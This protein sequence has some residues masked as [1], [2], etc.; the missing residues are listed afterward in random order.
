MGDIDLRK[1]R[2]DDI[3]IAFMGPT[4]SGKSNLIDVLTG[5]VG[6]KRLSGSKLRSCTQDVYAVRLLNHE[7]YGDRLVFVDTP[8]FD[9]TDRSDMEILRMIGKWLQRTYEASIKLAG[10]VYLHRITDNRMSGSPHRN[11]RMFGE[12]CGDRATSKVALVTTMWDRVNQAIAEKRQQEL[13]RNYF[14]ELLIR[15]AIPMRFNNTERAAWNIV[16]TIIREGDREEILLQEELV[17]LRR[18]LNETSAGR[19]IYNTFQKLLKDQ[20]EVVRELAR[21]AKAQNN[22]R[23]V[24]EMNLEYKRI[25]REFEK[26]FGQ[27]AELKVPLGRRIILY[28]FGKKSRARSLVLV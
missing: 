9:D 3:V 16:D 6:S 22:V 2:V 24:S 19:A 12:L 28:L 27:I 17:E 13:E 11:L 8:G 7:V 15:G 5:Q 25:Q 18:R 20:R 4:G 26:S 14:R 21:L 10:I 23:L 1:I